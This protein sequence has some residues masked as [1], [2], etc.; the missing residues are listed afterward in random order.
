M[1]SGA[2]FDFII[3][4]IRL[5]GRSGIDFLKE[6]GDRDVSPAVIMI[7]AYGTIESSI[8]AIKTGADDFI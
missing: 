6:I 7:S 8:E 4:D 3:C 2:G 1:D 5:P